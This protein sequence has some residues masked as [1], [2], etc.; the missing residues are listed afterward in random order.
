M[1]P[2]KETAGQK[3]FDVVCENCQQILPD[4][5]KDLFLPFSKEATDTASKGKACLC[6]FVMCRG[7]QRAH[8]DSRVQRVH[9]DSNKAMRHCCRKQQWVCEFGVVSPLACSLCFTLGL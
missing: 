7:V 3:K 4:S 9:I 1:I 5:K 2:A 8:L 6:D